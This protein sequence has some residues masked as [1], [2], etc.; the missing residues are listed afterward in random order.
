ML[1]YSAI[2]ERAL[3]LNPEGIAVDANDA[4]LTYRE[5]DAR[6]EALANLLVERGI[7]GAECVVG[8]C[9]PRS[10]AM[11]VALVAIV[12][13]GAA[14]LPLDVA[15]P[16]SRLR[17]LLEDSRP[18]AIVVTDETAGSFPAGQNLVDMGDVSASS[19][20]SVWP[21]VPSSAAAYIIYTSGT[22]GRPKATV[23]P[24]S[25]LEALAFAGRV[26]AFDDQESSSA[27]RVP[28][29]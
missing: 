2:F 9:V 17:Y 25:G 29:F 21:S 23:V 4:R 18:Q 24:H 15:H 19:G 11:I 10:A 22:T 6:A 27:D 3:R 28:F 5:L 12:R 26:L 1:T 13:T 8:I 7:G 20:A 14:Y 16:R